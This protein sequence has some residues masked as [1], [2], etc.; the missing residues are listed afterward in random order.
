MKIIKVTNKGTG[1]VFE[2]GVDGVTRI[3]ASGANYIAYVY[4]GEGSW[5]DTCTIDPKWATVE[6]ASA[7]GNG[8][9]PQRVSAKPR[10]GPHPWLAL[11]QLLE[12]VREGRRRWK[13]SLAFEIE[14]LRALGRLIS[15][16]VEFGFRLLERKQPWVIGG[17][18]FWW[19]LFY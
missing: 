6:E 10:A 1:K 12:A 13:Q 11:R 3:V 4:R 15:R 8:I 17:I 18:S 9:G 2:V 5:N 16:M 19:R 7:N 14:A